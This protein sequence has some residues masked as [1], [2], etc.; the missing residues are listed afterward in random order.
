MIFWRLFLLCCSRH[1]WVGLWHFYG[2]VKVGQFWQMFDTR[3]FSSG[4][5]PGPNIRLKNLLDFRVPSKREEETCSPLVLFLFVYFSIKT[6]SFFFLF[7]GKIYVWIFVLHKIQWKRFVETMMNFYKRAYLRY[8]TS[9]SKNF[10]IK[11]R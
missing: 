8:Q 11:E 6:V 1:C 7:H 3:R 5:S 4:R 2:R 9:W 10:V